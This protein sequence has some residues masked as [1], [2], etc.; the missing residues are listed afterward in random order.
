M[1]RLMKLDTEDKIVIFK[2]ILC[3]I[4]VVIQ[5]IIGDPLFVLLILIL[6][7]NICED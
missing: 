4:L 6:I 5:F 2:M 3:G 7:L 1:I